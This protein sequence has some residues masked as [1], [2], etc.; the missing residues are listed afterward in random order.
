MQVVAR[1]VDFLH[2]DTGL[3][4]I[5]RI[6]GRQRGVCFEAFASGLA[7]RCEGCRRADGGKV[8]PVDNRT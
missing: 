1:T 5:C 8:L 6:W 2:L 7:A 3:F 4:S